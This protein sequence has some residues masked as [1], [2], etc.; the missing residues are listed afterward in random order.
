MT[1]PHAA[2][3]ALGKCGECAMC[4]EPPAVV[5]CACTICFK[6]DMCTSGSSILRFPLAPIAFQTVSR[7]QRGS[8][9]T[10]PCV[11]EVDAL[12]CCR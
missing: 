1:E 4:P 5:Q 3:A 11:T 9:P 2:L 8:P 6:A 7:R 10:L 12:P